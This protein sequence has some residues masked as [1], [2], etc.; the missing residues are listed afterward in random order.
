MYASSMIHPH[1]RLEF[2]SPEKG[3][4]LVAT[5]FIPRGTITWVQDLLDQE[6]RSEEVYLLGEDY[7]EII[8]TYSF[9]NQLGH[10][11]L[12]WDH[13]RFVNH[14]F[15]SN[16]LTTAY[17]FEI[18]VRDI[19]PGEELTDDYGYLNIEEP[20][21]ALP[22]GTSRNVV[23]P[24]DLLHYHEEWDRQ[25]EENFPLIQ[26]VDQPL[27]H[28]LSSEVK[29]KVAAILRKETKMDSILACYYDPTKYSLHKLG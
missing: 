16:C 28:L 6:F 21:D 7:A 26:S 23:Y 1:T 11:V 25:L 22:E 2:I 8:Q 29:S 14:S 19:H 24:D 5:A 3:Y 17:N 12:C 20:F 13:A 10:Y 27:Y 15:R 4:G 18:A 9:R